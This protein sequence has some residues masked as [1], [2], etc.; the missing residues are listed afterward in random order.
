MY[1]DLLM[2]PDGVMFHQGEG[3]PVAMLKWMGRAWA[4]SPEG[5]GEGPRMDQGLAVKVLTPRTVVYVIRAGYVPEGQSVRPREGGSNR[6][7]T[8]PPVPVIRPCR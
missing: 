7:T 4:W 5:Y 6:A 1:G 3:N 2:I 8:P